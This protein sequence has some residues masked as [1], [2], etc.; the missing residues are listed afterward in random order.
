MQ[1]HTMKPSSEWAIL[2][3]SF[4]MPAFLEG[5][6]LVNQRKWT[7]VWISDMHGKNTQTWWSISGICDSVK[8]TSSTFSERLSQ[9]TKWL[10]KTHKYEQP[11]ICICNQHLER[12]SQDSAHIS[13][14]HRE[15]I[16]VGPPGQC[17]GRDSVGSCVTFYLGW[18]KLWW[19]QNVKGLVASLECL[20]D[21][22]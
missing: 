15:A 17:Q 9:E 13:V 2:S 6:Q 16:L 19:E 11:Q 3:T 14:R 18:R 5:T 4:P 20:S 1:E 12:Q 7:Q 21:L 22:V 10:R 8:S